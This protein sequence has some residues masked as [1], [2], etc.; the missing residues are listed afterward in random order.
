MNSTV[1]NPIGVQE[2]FLETILVL[3]TSPTPVKKED[4]EKK[5]DLEKSFNLSVHRVL[6]RECNRKTGEFL[7]SLYRS[8]NP[9]QTNEIKLL[10]RAVISEALRQ[11]LVEE[12]V[13]QE[14]LFPSDALPMGLDHNLCQTINQQFKPLGIVARPTV[15]NVTNTVCIVITKN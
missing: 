1:K 6:D 12:K 7:I 10:N 4:K 3:K 9:E 13:R 5:I 15:G 2:K 14:I 8:G 11:L